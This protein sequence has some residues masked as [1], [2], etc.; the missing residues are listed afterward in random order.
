MTITRSTLTGADRAGAELYDYA[1]VIGIDRYEDPSL[2]RLGGAGKDARAFIKWLETPSS[3]GTFDDSRII[4][5][6]PK[7]DYSDVRRAFLE[8]IRKV[9]D[10][11][12]TGRRLYIFVAGH[13]SGQKI[14]NAL[15]YS[16]EHS[17]DGDACFDVVDA[18]MKLGAIFRE[19]V[20]FVDCCRSFTPDVQP[21]PIPLPLPL[22]AGHRALQFHFHCFACR[23]NELAE[24]RRVKGGFRGVFS[25][26][27]LDALSGNV[28]SAVDY[29]GRVT[30]LSLM[31]YLSTLSIGARADHDP[32][33]E[34]ELRNIVLAKGFKPR[35]LPLEI[36]LKKRSSIGLFNGNDYKPLDWKCEKTKNGTYLIERQEPWAIIVTVPKVKRF[37]DAK[38]WAV[39]L[40]HESYKTL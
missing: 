26:H 29:E 37:S 28:D 5:R 14:G 39:V 21:L 33:D 27:L 9:K 22:K 31:R 40:P 20:L 35:R 23:I 19:I 8:L 13:G 15:V 18:A 10:V 32:R 25:R 3:D 34:S 24:E 12:G 6:V 11:Q 16:S 36:R 2:Q 1:M 7:A 30:A 4:K 38:E 17:Q